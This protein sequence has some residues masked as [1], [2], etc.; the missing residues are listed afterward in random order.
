MKQSTKFYSILKPIILCSLVFSLLLNANCQIIVDENSKEFEEL[1]VSLLKNLNKCY[2]IAK[3]I[4]KT[5]NSGDLGEGIKYYGLA[6]NDWLELQRPKYNIPESKIN[7]INHALGFYAKGFNH[8][9]NLGG[10]NEKQREKINNDLEGWPFRETKTEK[11]KKNGIYEI[12]LEPNDAM[13]ITLPEEG[14]WCL[15]KISNEGRIWLD[16]YL[17]NNGHGRFDIKYD[18]LPIYLGSE[19]YF[20]IRNATYYRATII[21]TFSQC[22]RKE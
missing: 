16:G 3:D 5:G 19:K 9:G 2:L 15:T 22:K 14:T 18:D 10:H 11:D 4:A 8:I 6:Y 7:I 17:Y 12:K 20:E 21:V 1:R 13:G